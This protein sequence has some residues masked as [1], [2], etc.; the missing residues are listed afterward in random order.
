VSRIGVLSDTHDNL[1]KVR[2][3]VKVF[4][5]LGV[6]KV[7][8]C[9]D[10][11]AQFVLG[12][13]GRLEMPLVGVYGNCDGDRP[14]LERRAREFGF[15]LEHGPFRL[16]VGGRR[17]VMSHEPFANIAECDYYVHGHTHHL[18]HEGTAPVIVN[19]GEACGWLTTRSTVAMIDT[20]SD[21]V[22]FID[23]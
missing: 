9:G 13:M 17:F 8:H 2:A 1:D 19:P 3:A 14:A 15:D 22:D 12:E 18:R 21:R 5:R 10:F 11:V 7:L 4:N 6:E 20:E 16:T 23:L